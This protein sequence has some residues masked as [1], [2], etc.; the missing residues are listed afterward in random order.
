MLTP[1]EA[2]AV[3]GRAEKRLQRE[4]TEDEFRDG[5]QGL[6]TVEDH[7]LTGSVSL[8]LLFPALNPRHLTLAIFTFYSASSHCLN[9]VLGFWY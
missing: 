2:A 8:S 3:I 1:G 5:L 4:F 6:L 9:S 7:N